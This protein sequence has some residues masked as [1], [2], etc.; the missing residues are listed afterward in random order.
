MNPSLQEE[1]LALCFALIQIII[2]LPGTFIDN[3]PEILHPKNLLKLKVLVL[4]LI[5][6]LQY[7]WFLPKFIRYIGII[8]ESPGRRQNR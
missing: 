7:Y 5:Q 3:L 2:W 6:S 8:H 4:D 1:N